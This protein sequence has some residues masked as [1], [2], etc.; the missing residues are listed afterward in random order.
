M[1]M[2]ILLIT[3]ISIAK[4]STGKPSIDRYSP[5]WHSIIRK[6]VCCAVLFLSLTSCS[7]EPFEGT[8]SAAGGMQEFYFKTDGYVVQLLAG[9][10]VAEY[11]FEKNGNEIKIY[12]NEKTAQVFILQDNGVLIGPGGIK[13]TPKI[14]N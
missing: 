6:L 1:I 7:K 13:L 2:T 10:K 12:M 9:N 11:N 4:L 5:T 14:Y 3:N 8:Y